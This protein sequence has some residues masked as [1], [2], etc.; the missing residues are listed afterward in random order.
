MIL[1][2]TGLLKFFIGLIGVVGTIVF[3][4]LSVF[5]R[6]RTGK[7]RYA[8]LTFLT[9]FILILAITGLEFLMYP[10]NGKQDQLVLTGFREAPLGAY[11]LGVYDDSTWEL[12]NSSREIE[13]RGTYT[14]SGDTLHLKTLGGTAF[15]NG[16][17]RNSFVISGDDLIEVENSGIKGLKIGLNKLNGL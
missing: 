1:F 14:I 16:D 13:V 15:Y 11:W 7:L 5:K 9:T 8:G 4:V 3:L 10:T 2:A 6:T 17:T 12:G